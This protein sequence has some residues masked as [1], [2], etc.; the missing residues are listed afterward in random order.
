MP[1]RDV[2]LKEKE[3]LTEKEVITFIKCEK[4]NYKDIKT[5]K[6]QRQ[7]FVIREQLKNIWYS[8]CIKA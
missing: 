3:C 1:P 5:W 8:H 2:L 7:G 4:Y 6:N